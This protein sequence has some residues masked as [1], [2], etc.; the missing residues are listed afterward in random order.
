VD[1][2]FDRKSIEILTY[3]QCENLKKCCYSTQAAAIHF[4]QSNT[5]IIA[6][7]G[8][9]PMDLLQWLNNATTHFVK[10]KNVFNNEEIQVHA[11][12]HSALGLHEANILQEIDQTEVTEKSPMFIQL[13]NFINKFDE[14]DNKCNISVTGHSLG[15]GLASLFSFVLLVRVYE[16]S[17]SGVYTYGQPLVGNR[18]YAQ[19]LNNKLGNR[20][21]RW[22]NHT[23]KKNLVVRN[24]FYA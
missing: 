8:T 2:G 12:F 24:H 5:I 19:I 21:H 4:N 17:I 7:R 16:S 14:D 1:W 6:F 23:L 9:E 15:G 13:L 11:G 18:R 10:I 22:V 3:T 20:F